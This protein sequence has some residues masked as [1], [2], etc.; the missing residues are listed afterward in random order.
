MKLNKIVEKQALG[1]GHSWVK[2]LKLDNCQNCMTISTKLR[3]RKDH[4]VITIYKKDRQNLNTSIGDIIIFKLSNYELIRPVRKDF[5]ISLPKNI[6]KDKNNGN[7]I[8]LSILKITKNGISRKRPASMVKNNK[9][10]IRHF[11]P[12]KTIFGYPIHIMERGDNSS[13]IWYSIGGG[14]RHVNIKNFVDIDKIAEL[15]GFYYGDGSTSKSIRSFRLTNC[16]PSVLNYCLDVLG[17]IGINRE[18]FKAQIIYSTNEELTED[19]KSKCINSWSESLNINKENIVSVTKADNV[20]ET[21]KYGSARIFIDNA[22]L[23]EIF[24]HGLLEGILQ[25]ITKPKSIIDKRLLEGFIRGLLAAEGSVNL[26]E[27]GSVVKVGIS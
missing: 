2:Y 11:I 1:T 10:D 5:H 21:L 17:D 27:N 22:V 4:F 23:V 7:K 3:E 19:I 6:L 8:K 13:S 12:K 26:N 15:I 18:R 20:R 9:I 25:R 16:E 24:L 14:V